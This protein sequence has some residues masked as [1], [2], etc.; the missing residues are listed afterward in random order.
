MYE[1]DVSGTPEQW[2]CRVRL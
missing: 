1:E 2:F